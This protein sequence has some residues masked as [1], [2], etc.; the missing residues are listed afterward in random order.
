M[1]GH[2]DDDLL[3]SWL[4]GQV[5]DRTAA[6]MAEHIEDCPS[7]A[8][9][10]GALDPLA[11]VWTLTYD[12]MPPSDLVATVL[13]RSVPPRR[14][15]WPRVLPFVGGAALP[16]VALALASPDAGPWEELTTVLGNTLAPDALTAMGL[17]LAGA[18][19]VTGAVAVARATALEPR[20]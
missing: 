16:F 9:R 14:S 6:W 2:P 11:E 18:L 8:A 4:A 17:L 10:S 1:T 3:A 13:A 7:C 19:A 15:R 20:L 5:G 12:P